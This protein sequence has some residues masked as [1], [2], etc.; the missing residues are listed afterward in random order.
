MKRSLLVIVAVVLCSVCVV[1]Q[2]A[3]DKLVFKGDEALIDSL[4]RTDYPYIFPIWG[5]K[6]RKMGVTLPLP[7]WVRTTSGRNPTSRSPN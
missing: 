1:A 5:D 7:A 2:N 4:K 3:P 6:V